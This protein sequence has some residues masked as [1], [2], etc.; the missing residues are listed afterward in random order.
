MFSRIHGTM[1]LNYGSILRKGLRLHQYI[2]W[3]TCVKKFLAHSKPLVTCGIRRIINLMKEYET[4]Y[5]NERFVPYEQVL[6]TASAHLGV[7]V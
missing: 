1:S 5:G 2:R 6:G 4:N 7:T 3:T